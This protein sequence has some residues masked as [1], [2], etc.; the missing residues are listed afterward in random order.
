MSVGTLQLVAFRK[1]LLH[2]AD[3]YQYYKLRESLLVDTTDQRVSLTSA[4]E[5][6]DCLIWRNSEGLISV[7]MQDGLR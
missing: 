5:S 3:C 2:H 7:A 1:Q 4:A 6:R